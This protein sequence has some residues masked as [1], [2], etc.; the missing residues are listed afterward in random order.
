MNF[1][2]L[3]LFCCIFLFNSERIYS[4]KQ[5]KTLKDSVGIMFKNYFELM[6]SKKNIDS[7]RL[8]VNGKVADINSSVQN[9]KKKVD[10][11]TSKFTAVNSK[12]LELNKILMTNRSQIETLTNEEA[13]SQEQVI[14]NNINKIINTTDFVSTANSSLALLNLGA[15]IGAYQNEIATLNN[16]NDETLGFSLSTKIKDILQTTI[17]KSNKNVN[18]SRASKIIAVVDNIIKHP[19]LESVANA[20][21]IVSSI[22]SIFDLIVGIAVRGD[23]ITVEDISKF[24]TDLKVYLDHYEGLILVQNDFSKQLNSINVRKDALSL[25]LSTYTK[26]QITSLRPEG[27]SLSDKNLPLNDIINKYYIR[28]SIQNQIDAIRLANTKQGKNSMLDTR[29]KY[30]DYALIQAKFIRDEI[31]TLGKEYIAAYKSYQKALEMVLLRSVQS[32]IGDKELVLKKISRLKSLTTEV[33]KKYEEGINIENLNIK[34]K[35]ISK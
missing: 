28:N 27:I 15:A 24:K 3:L 9:N 18:D 22:K 19:I 23:D 31:E 33:C 20:V 7:L 35:N 14:S 25:L 11:L 12:V 5:P 32:K 4:Q 1:K 2:L 29:L 8:V 13:S 10:S 21:P 16:P 34:F 6:K 30:P 17:I 26:D